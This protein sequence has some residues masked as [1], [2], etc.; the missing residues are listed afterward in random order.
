MITATNSL[1]VAKLLT[2]L[3]CNCVKARV[4]KFVQWRSVCVFT[5]VESNYVINIGPQ[6]C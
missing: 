1:S 5:M 2:T 4:C 3:Y 6:F